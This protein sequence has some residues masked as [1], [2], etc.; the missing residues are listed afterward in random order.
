[1][2]TA[3]LTVRVFRLGRSPSTFGPASS[4]MQDSG[5][6]CAISLCNYCWRSSSGL[7]NLSRVKN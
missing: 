2:A 4:P 3:P 7:A 1:M 6:R 5:P